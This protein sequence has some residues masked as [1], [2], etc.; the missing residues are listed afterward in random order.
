ML[1]NPFDIEWIQHFSSEIGLLDLS[2]PQPSA[3]LNGFWPLAPSPNLQ[4]LL[5]L[6]KFLQQ[7]MFTDLL[8]YCFYEDCCFE[9]SSM[10]E[11]FVSIFCLI[12]C[13]QRYLIPV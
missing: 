5:A 8:F 7:S 6:M 2:S 11:N 12:L 9:I 4:V 13:R 10:V 1:Q 3:L